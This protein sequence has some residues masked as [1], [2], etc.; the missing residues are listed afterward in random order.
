MM[1]IAKKPK[2][3]KNCQK[4]HYKWESQKKGPKIDKN[5]HFQK[6]GWEIVNIGGDGKYFLRTEV[7]RFNYFASTE[8]VCVR[9]F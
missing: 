2:N 3:P 1:K 8:R 7:C 9:V 6:I 5:H 4:Y